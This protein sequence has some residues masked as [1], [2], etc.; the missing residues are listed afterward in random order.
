ME[1]V[2]YNNNPKQK[3]TTDCVIRAISFATDKT[4]EDV[5]R[6][7]VEL[8]IGNGLMVNDRK[9]WKT[10]LKKL[11]YNMEKMPKT[12]DN[13]RYT[14]EQFADEIAHKGWTY[15]V[16]ITNHITVIKDKKLYDIWNCK[17]K[18]VGNYWIIYKI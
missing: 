11:G 7:L 14:V 10:Y 18:C 5:Y 12:L 9:N 15:I 4:W 13:K 8:G 2:K 1:F 3:I 17:N 16:K 6:D